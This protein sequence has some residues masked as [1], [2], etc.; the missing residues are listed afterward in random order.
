MRR[1]LIVKTSSM[2][3]VLH[4]LPALTDAVQVFPDLTFDWVVE[5]SFAQ[6]PGWHSAVDRVIPVAIR[7]WRKNW[8][9]RDIRDERRRF[10]DAVRSQ[11]YDAV[12]DAQGLIKSA[13]LVTRLARGRKHGYDRHSIREPL[14]S[15]FYDEKYAVSKTQ[16]AVERIRQLFALSLGYEK[17]QTQGD[18]AIAVHFLNNRTVSPDAVPYLVCLHATTRDAKHWPESHWRALFAQLADTDLHVRLPWGAPHEQER[19]LRLAEGFTHVHVLPKLSL[20]DVA[21]EIAGAEGVISVD[22][23]LSHLTAALDKPNITLYGPTDPGLIGGYGKGQF[24]LTSKDGD[25][26]SV[27]A[28][29]VL[30]AMAEHMPR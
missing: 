30:A 23:G 28:D 14:A 7:R 18:Y 3:D 9:R 26:S 5:E 12:I 8:F 11:T 27:S 2:G 10:R 17:P 13:L 21:A 16:H 24:A 19:A 15:F 29:D 1:V 20:A 25:L 4:T 6:I 22:T